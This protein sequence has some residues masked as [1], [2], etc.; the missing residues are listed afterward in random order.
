MRHLSLALIL[1]IALTT[2]AFGACGFG[3]SIAGGGCQGAITTTSGSNQTWTVPSDWNS[4]SNKVEVI[5]SGG[6]GSN[7]ANGNGGCGGS[8]AT[9]SNISL[10]GGGSATYFLNVGGAGAAAGAGAAG[11]AGGD[12]WFNGT[13]LAGS[14]VGAKGGAGGN[15]SG[16]TG[17]TSGCTV[18]STGNIG[19]TTYYGGG[20][21]NQASG[22][23]GGGGGGAASPNGTGIKGG[24]GGG[25]GVAGGGGDE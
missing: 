15:N 6:G 18:A 17:T 23:A 22:L 20:S 25:G 19:T 12:A 10:T 21:G 7:G 8:Y 1:L 5:A 4:A 11:T 13:T 16:A 3:S 24:N 14:S 9:K 2:Q